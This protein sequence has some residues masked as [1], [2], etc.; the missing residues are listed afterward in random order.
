MK[1]FLLKRRRYVSLGRLKS[2]CVVLRFRKLAGA[3]ECRGSAHVQS[4]AQINA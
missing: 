3:Y 2:R 1:N 4:L